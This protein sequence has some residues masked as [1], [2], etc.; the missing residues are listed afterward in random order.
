MEG[1]EKAGKGRVQVETGRGDQRK[2][3]EGSR[4]DQRGDQD[5]DQR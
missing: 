3:E 5:G 4:G 1:R 2:P